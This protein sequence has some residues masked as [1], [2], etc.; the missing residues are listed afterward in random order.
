MTNGRLDFYSLIHSL[1]PSLGLRQLMRTRASWNKG[2]KLLG[3]RNTEAENV[4]PGFKKVKGNLQ[5]QE[6]QE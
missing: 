3:Q 2:G 5:S 6:Q 1:A 4:G